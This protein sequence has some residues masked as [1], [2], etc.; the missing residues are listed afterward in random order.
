LELCNLYKEEGFAFFLSVD[1]EGT[2]FDRNLKGNAEC[3]ERLLELNTANN[4]YTILF[5]TPYF[6]EMLDELGLVSKIKSDYKVIFG[7]HIHPENLPEKI[8]DQCP[9]IKNNIKY[10]AEYNYKEQREIICETLKFI[11]NIGL[12][13]IQGFRGGYFSVNDETIEAIRSSTNIKWESHNIYRKEYSVTQNLLQAF[14]VFSYDDATEFRLEDYDE[15]VFDAM[16]TDAKLNKKKILAITH[17]YLLDEWDF[18]YKRDRIPYSIIDIMQK[19][20]K[21]IEE[22]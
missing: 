16:I 21:K 7:L 22:L 19:V 10:I 11:E 13:P 12:E 4:I 2:N 20:I 8:K 18:H 9:F 17:S 6:A 14:P 1:C 3:L 5:I 15:A